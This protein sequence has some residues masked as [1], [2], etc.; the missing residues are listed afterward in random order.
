MYE[1]CGRSDNV[2]IT[3]GGAR[4]TLSRTLVHVASDEP[5]RRYSPSPVGFVSPAAV[6]QHRVKKNRVPGL[7]CLNVGGLTHSS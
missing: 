1:R 4:R 2:Q 5:Q 3:H 7:K 6:R